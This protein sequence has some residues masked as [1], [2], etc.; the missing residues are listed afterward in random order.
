[1]KILCNVNTSSPKNNTNKMRTMILGR[2]YGVI[3]QTTG[4]S[5][6]NYML[7]RTMLNCFHT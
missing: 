1:M 4:T 7:N 5:K 3:P 2:Q 6:H